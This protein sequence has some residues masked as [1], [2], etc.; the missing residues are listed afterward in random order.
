MGQSQTP[1]NYYLGC[2][3]ALW[4]DTARRLVI[5]NLSAIQKGGFDIQDEDGSMVS[6]GRSSMDEFKHE[7][8]DIQRPLIIVKSAAF[9]GRIILSGDIGFAEAFMLREVECSDLTSLITI[10]I[11]NRPTLTMA[12]NTSLYQRGLLIA[13]YLLKSTNNVSTAKLNAA[14]H[15]SLSNDMF[16]AFLSP[17]MT[18]SAALWLP[19]SHPQ[20]AEDNLEKAQMR[21]L[22]SIISY[23][24][25]KSSDH[26]LEI[27][28]GWG[29]FAIL[30]A[31][32]TGCRI[33][34]IT[35]SVEQKRLAEKRISDAGLDSQITVLLNDYRELQGYQHAFDKV[36]SIEMIEHVGHEYMSTYFKCVDQYL[37]LDGG[38]GVFVSSTIPESRYSTYLK[39]EDFIQKYIFPGGHLPTTS[40]LVAAID[41]G[42]RGRLVVEEIRSIG[43]HYPQTLRSWRENFQQ[44]FADKISPA[45][46]AQGL[47]EQDI[48]IFERKWEYYFSYCEAAF[49]T[50]SVGDVVIVA[51]REGCTDFL[52]DVPL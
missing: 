18:Y 30:A 27:G 21:K 8:Y 49:R 45:L 4:Q 34:T 25:I 26:V 29:S 28:T 5:Q 42:S 40:G 20:Y 43:A 33:T 7:P 39:G 31:K 9:W 24:K 36:V 50:K 32:S 1:Y 51:G 47:G 37:K 35:L 23:A 14:G 41:S 11:H 3:A 48:A 44:N 2:I 12:S 6:I 16:E 17:D 46:G 13:R 15:Y 38:I 52:L 19:R 22:E 10:L